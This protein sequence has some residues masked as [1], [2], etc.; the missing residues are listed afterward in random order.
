MKNKKSGN[1]SEKLNMLTAAINLI[2][3]ILMAIDALS[4]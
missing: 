2:T 3:A 1:N 4:N